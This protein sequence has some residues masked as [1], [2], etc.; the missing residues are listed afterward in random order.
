MPPAIK[1]QK[2]L[3]KYI[4]IVGLTRKIY[5]KTLEIGPYINRSHYQKYNNIAT[6]KLIDAK[7][8]CSL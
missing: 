7:R 8:L 1:K 6:I 2:K 3:R 4:L 5:E